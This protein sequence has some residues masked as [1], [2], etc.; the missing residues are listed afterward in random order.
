M[1]E[2]EISLEQ[3]IWK[4]IMGWR[5][6]LILGVLF[7]VI[8]P[9]VQYMRSERA[10]QGKIKSP[11]QIE[12]EQAAKLLTQEEKVDVE[13][14]FKI[15]KR[16]KKARTYIKKSILM[17]LDP[18]K[19]DELLLTY[20]VKG[21]KNDPMIAD[22]LTAYVIAELDKTQI[23]DGI[24]ENENPE[25]MDELVS[26]YKYSGDSA[27]VKT[28]EIR[29]YGRNQEE[30]KEIDGRMQAAMEK[31]IREL[32][33]TESGAKIIL[34]STGIKTVVDGEI[35][36]RQQ[37]M[38]D[39]YDAETRRITELTANFSE[40]QKTYLTGLGKTDKEIADED[41]PV[42]N[43]SI[44]KKYILLGGIVGVFLGMCCIAG[45]YIL[46]GRLREPEE[47]ADGF[48]LR[49]HGIVVKDGKKKG[50]DAFL[51]RLKNRKK[52]MIPEQEAWELAAGNVCLY[53]RKNEIGHLFITGSEFSK[54]DEDGR[55]ILKKKLEAQG[56][57]VFFGDNI[58]YDKEALER[59]GDCEGVLLIELVGWSRYAE[60]EK[61]L[62]TLKNQNMNMIGCI[63][64][65]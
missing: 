17:Q 14:V 46:S 28:V 32:E 3:L 13:N 2:Q 51:L 43:I 5:V 20:S 59:A 54:V 31:K 11:T 62:K 64:I 52:V 15:Q 47:L 37:G 24:I 25:Y 7:A 19:V 9:G 45:V 56:T 38:Q 41:K 42:K 16:K 58:N 18:Y 55:N 50:I 23:F 40:Q 60:I 44:S 30:L 10:Y 63:T 33:Q 36:D 57:Q 22:A 27:K 12:V 35:Y 65:A 34:L 21:T 61:Q 4:M 6:W 53:C 26:A 8:V 39:R 48:L 1:R 49:Q 29:V